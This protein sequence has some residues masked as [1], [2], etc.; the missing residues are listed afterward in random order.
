MLGLLFASLAL[1][2]LHTFD[3]DISNGWWLLIAVTWLTAA[4]FYALSDLL[5]PTFFFP[6]MAVAALLPLPWFFLH[7]FDA[8]QPGYVFGFWVWGA[9][10]ALVSEVAFRLPVEK[11]KKYHW[12]FLAGSVPLFLTAFSIALI[13]DKP[14]LTFAIFALTRLYTPLCTWFTRAGMCGAR[15]YSADCLLISYSFPCQIIE[16]L[17]IPLVYQLLIVEHIARRARVIHKNTSFAEN[18]ITLAR[19]CTGNFCFTVWYCPGAR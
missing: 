2:T 19:N 16:R 5:T 11:I 4:S 3:S 9:I 10:L 12:A 13:W 17:E 14:V 8:T 6:W 7:T 18:R 15:P 1:A